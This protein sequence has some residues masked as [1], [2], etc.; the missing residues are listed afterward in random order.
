MNNPFQEMLIQ[1]LI[2]MPVVLKPGKGFNSYKIGRVIKI[3]FDTDA[4]KGFILVDEIQMEA[5]HP[6]VDPNQLELPL[7]KTKEN[8]THG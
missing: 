5:V 2:G 1:K 8:E 4:M 3:Q 6:H 7:T